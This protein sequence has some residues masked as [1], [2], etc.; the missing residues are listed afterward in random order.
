MNTT[1]IRPVLAE[2]LGWTLLHSLWQGLII[3]ISLLWILRL[4]KSTNPKVKYYLS[5]SA[6]VLMVVWMLATFSHTYMQ[7]QE[8]FQ[9]EWQVFIPGIR[10]EIQQEQTTSWWMSVQDQL[11]AFV[12]SYAREMTGMWLFGVLIFGVRWIGSVYYTYRLR[13]IQTVPALDHWQ[14]KVHMLRLKM[15]INREVRLVSSARIDVPMVIG[16]LKPVILFPVGM[17]SGLAPEQVEAIIAHELAHVKRYDFVINLM[18]S[19]LEVLLFYHPA[20]WW[21]NGRIS[22]A[23]EHCCDDIAVATCGNARLYAEALYQLEEKLQQTT[24]AMALQGRKHQLLNRIKR[25]CLGSRPANRGETGKAGFALGL[26]LAI[27]A[28]AWLQVPSNLNASQNLFDQS[29][30]NRTAELW[31]LEVPSF[32]L[33][34]DNPRRNDNNIT[35]D[36]EPFGLD[37]F[38]ALASEETSMSREVIQGL[39]GD[40]DNF[41]SLISISTIS[42][43]DTPPPP[44]VMP[45]MPPMPP[46][47]V[48][49]AMPV[50]PVMPVLPPI[51]GAYLMGRI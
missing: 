45:P 14:Q 33:G 31:N 9:S 50:M 27:A 36:E 42:T 49:P 46:M 3:A 26:L 16:H 39:S 48:M 29:K 41:Q 1:L 4:A 20:Y 15:H 5:I 21:I 19:T 47:P 6:L 44:F 38:E 11:Y 17:M 32:I 2:A 37:H 28:L 43:I 22:E 23:R 30:R 10:Q 51:A 25:I 34:I 8:Q 13:H 35:K 40:W 18:L 24:L 12:Q 7:L